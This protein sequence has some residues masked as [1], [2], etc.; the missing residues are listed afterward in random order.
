M[1]TDSLQASD[2]LDAARQAIDWDVDAELP[3]VTLTWESNVARQ[4]PAGPDAW[5][6]QH[7]QAVAAVLPDGTLLAR[8]WLPRGEERSEKLAAAAIEVL[9][10]T[11]ARLA[12]TAAQSSA[13][14]LALRR[15]IAFY[16]IADAARPLGHSERDTVATAIRAALEE[17]VAGADELLDLIEHSLT[18]NPVDTDLY[19]GRAR[20]EWAAEQAQH[21]MRNAHSQD[22]Y[23]W[24]RREDLER[25]IQQLPTLEE[26]ELDRS[27][28]TVR[29][30]SRVSTAAYARQ[31]DAAR[32]ALAAGTTQ[33]PAARRTGLSQG[34]SAQ[35]ARS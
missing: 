20:P 4:I 24:E 28:A 33:P 16:A 27:T 8:R 30:A 14:G 1:D 2:L 13:R 6:I 10:E 18:V 21:W 26:V 29:E 5:S 35:I 34:R 3:H 7:D 22:A 25:A 23:D 17:G 31:R 9:S 11:R 32:P 12:G 15:V 19:R